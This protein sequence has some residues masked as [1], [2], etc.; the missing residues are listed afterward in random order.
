MTSIVPVDFANLAMFGR[1]APGL[2]LPKIKPSHVAVMLTAHIR[3]GLVFTIRPI[4]ELGRVSV[5]HML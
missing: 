3:V 1:D 5:G 4:G 2:R